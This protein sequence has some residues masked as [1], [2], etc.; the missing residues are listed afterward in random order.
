MEPRCRCIQ[1]FDKLTTNGLR[2]SV[3]FILSLSKDLVYGISNGFESPPAYSTTSACSLWN[4][5]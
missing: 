5:T 4:L 3:P 2:S 1:W